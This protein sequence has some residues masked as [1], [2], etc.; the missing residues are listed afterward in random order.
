MSTNTSED[1]DSFGP[2][3]PT[4]GNTL[5]EA[6][7]KKFGK[8]N[9]VK[10]GK[11]FNTKGWNY[12][13]KTSFPCVKCGTMIESFR[14]RYDS[15]KKAKPYHWSLY[16]NKCETLIGP[17]KLEPDQRE[18]LYSTVSPI[19]SRTSA[20]RIERIERTNTPKKTSEKDRVATDV[21][22]EI[23][24]LMRATSAQLAEIDEFKLIGRISSVMSGD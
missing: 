14:C 6:I 13:G 1:S 4:F 22:Y 8:T 7:T 10:P 21:I 3:L 18:I 23:M 12:S 9:V 17:S 5:Q 15:A 19:L 16:C 11:N 2:N 24:Q 20:E